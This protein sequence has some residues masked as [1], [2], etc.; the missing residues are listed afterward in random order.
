MLNKKLLFLIFFFNYIFTSENLLFEENN[1]FP[2]LK[3][4]KDEAKTKIFNF[5]RGEAKKYVLKYPPGIE[6]LITNIASTTSIK[7]D[8]VAINQIDSLKSKHEFPDDVIQKFKKI[9]YVKDTISYELFKFNIQRSKTSIENVFGVVTR[10]DENNIYFSYVK[11]N[12]NAKA[13][14]QYN[15]VPYRKC[16]NYIVARRCKTK[17]K[18]VKR[19]YNEIEL[20]NIKTALMAKFYE[21]LN[22]VLDLDQQ[23]IIDLFKQFVKAH[24]KPNPKDSEK[25]IVNQKTTLDFHTFYIGLNG[26]ENRLKQLGFND[27]TINNIKSCN[28][29]GKHVQLYHEIRDEP[30]KKDFIAGIAL[31]TGNNILLSYAIGRGEVKLYHNYCH[32]TYTKKKRHRLRKKRETIH[33]NED[34]DDD[35]ECV[36]SCNKFKQR[37]PSIPDASKAGAIIKQSVF[38]ELTQGINKILNGIHF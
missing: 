36:Q 35:D 5:L 1:E 16:R 10:L 3:I 15:S 22:S 7:L 24:V 13:I 28:T 18:N 21:T 19:G 30:Q 4:S 20:N 17:H 31:N 38:A 2:N 27:A 33:V 26:F 32:Y 23:K 34:C 25:Y 12:A 6:K 9:K 11:G 8:Q 14:P 37:N 29:N